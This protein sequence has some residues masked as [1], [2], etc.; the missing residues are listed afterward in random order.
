MVAI[1][2]EIVGG[3]DKAGYKVTVGGG[4]SVAVDDGMR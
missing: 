2:C 3:V 4:S 1:S